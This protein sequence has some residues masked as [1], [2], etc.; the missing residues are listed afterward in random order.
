[1]ESKRAGARDCH[2]SRRR[3]TEP[4]RA[5][6]ARKLLDLAWAVAR[7]IWRPARG[8]TVIHDA[9]QRLCLRFQD[10]L[11]VLATDHDALERVH[12][13]RLEVASLSANTD[14]Q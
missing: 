10:R 4:R 7:R 2:A 11:S 14:R 5:C 12:K 8:F 1:M 13:R 6:E 3:P 9:L